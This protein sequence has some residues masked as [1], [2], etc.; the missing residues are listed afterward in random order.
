MV[1]PFVCMRMIAQACI[2]YYYYNYYF[3]L[4]ALLA[5]M[6]I[7]ALAGLLLRDTGSIDLYLY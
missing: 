1:G 2:N 7:I 5:S 6:C 3:I 4:L